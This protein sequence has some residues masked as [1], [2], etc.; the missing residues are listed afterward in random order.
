MHVY[1]ETDVLIIGCGI[2]GATA[3]L[4]LAENGIDTTLI[5]K[6]PD[7]SSANTY[8]AQG[9]I[10]SLGD[11]DSP[12]LFMDDIKKSGGGINYHKAVE[13]AVNLSRKLVNE[14][15]IDKLK[16][17]FSGSNGQ[18]DLARE[19][20]H[21]KRRVLNVKD[22]TGKVIQEN[23][24][25]YLEKLDKLKILF[26]HTAIDILTY[27]HHSTNF[28]RLYEEPEAI[29]AYVLNRESEKVLRIFAKKV[30]LASGGLSSIFLHSTNP[31][32]VVGNGIAMAYRAGARMTNLEYIQFHP[33][34][35]Y[36]R[37]ADSFLISEAVRGEGAK[38]MNRKGDYFMQKYSP[39]G[40]LAP[41]DEV[42]RAIYEEMIKYD[43][44]YV[45]LD[46]AS[47]AKINIRER[48]PTIYENCKKYGMDIETSPIPV[49]PAAHYSCGGVSADLKGRTSLKNLYAVG[50]VAC[51][52]VHG[53]NRLASVSLLE[54]LVWGVKAAEDILETIDG[55]RMPYVIM[56][57]PAWKYPH[58]QEKLD[59]A[60]VWQD[61]V[62]VRYTMWNYSGIIRTTKRLERARSDLD[63][64]RHRII[65]FYRKTE[66]TNSII[67]LRDCVQTALLVVDAALRNK[68]SRG[69]HYIEDSFG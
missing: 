28:N 38:L 21:S 60:L 65:K 62:T 5:S 22:M 49:V 47:F 15:L 48:F 37:E 45:L 34:S 44:N 16:I 61:L 31:R 41:R 18:Y 68:T 64:L 8:Y 9:G 58:P 40:D 12:E 7:P 25:R 53:A 6:G 55:E 1:M 27:P 69:A 63:Y 20:A 56:E 3:A 57:T 17:P 14:I 4:I 54:G 59:P 43:D 23:F 30:I 13:Q 29:G 35:L 33:T 66:I 42:S 52:G 11:D 32:D 51:T 10:A 24:Y 50:E 67:D 46:L 19:G 39:M 26:N 36:H 2:A